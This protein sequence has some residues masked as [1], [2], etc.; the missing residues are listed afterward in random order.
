SPREVFQCIVNHGSHDLT[1][2]IEPG[3]VFW[4]RARIG[5]DSGLTELRDGTEVN[6]RRATQS[7]HYDIPGETRTSHTELVIAQ[8]AYI[9]SQCNHPHIEKIIGVTMID[10]RI[11]IVSPELPSGCR[12]SWQ[13]LP[14]L[15]PAR[16]RK[17]SIQIADAIAYLHSKDIVR[18]KS[19]CLCS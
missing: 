4:G 18:T 14:I 16:R 9:L 7:A 10:D 11:A 1:D 15:D 2:E 5:Y 13:L 8:E 6:V 3:G 17:M 12:N 19:N